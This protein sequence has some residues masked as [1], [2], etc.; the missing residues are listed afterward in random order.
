[1]S[2]EENV[3]TI[4][5]ELSGIENIDNSNSLQEDL[6]LDSLAMVTLLIEI[7]DIFEIQ[8]DEADMNPF[9][10]NTVQDVISMVERYGGDISES[11]C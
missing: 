8:L 9:D 10:L 5:F 2:V 3:K 6:A 4:L 1:M 7:E 11:C